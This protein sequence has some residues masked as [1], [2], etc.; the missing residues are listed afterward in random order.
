MNEVGAAL[1]DAKAAY[2]ADEIPAAIERFTAL[3][4]QGVAEACQ[5]LGF[6]LKT[7]E[8]FSDPERSR[9]WYGKYLFL[10][11]R[12]AE[13]GDSSALL[14]LG[15]HYQYGELV[16]TNYE[17]A[18]LLF[19][20]A[21]QMGHAE[22]QFHLSNLFLYGWCGCPQDDDQYIEWLSRAADAE[23]PEA[24]FKKGTRLRAGGAEAEG[25]C[26]IR[27]SADL[28]FWVAQEYLESSD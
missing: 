20:R 16:G 3:A 12:A 26:L 17:K 19:L 14:S 9:L 10:L 22:A 6:I 13:N 23:H 11:R 18:R 4:E 25:L 7:E 21:A 28:G 27:R 8:K 2:E 5:Y 24:L 15:K 1:L